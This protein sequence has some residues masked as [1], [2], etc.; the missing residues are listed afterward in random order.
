MEDCV[1]IMLVGLEHKYLEVSEFNEGGQSGGFLSGIDLREEGVAED[2]TGGGRLGGDLW[3]WRRGAFQLTARSVEAPR[4]VGFRHTSHVT[5]TG[6]L[7][8]V[9]DCAYCRFSERTS[10]LF[11]E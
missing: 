8:F 4:L 6:L 10:A 11:R 5:G 2:K 7:Q 9:E 1:E 3:E